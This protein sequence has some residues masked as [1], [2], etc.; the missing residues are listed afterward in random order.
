M[1][2]TTSKT[3]DRHAIL[4]AIKRRYGSMAALAERHGTDRR[5]LTVALGRPY[6]K[7]EAIIAKALGVSAS[8]LWP[9][10]YGATASARRKKATA[11]PSSQPEK[12]DIANER[13]A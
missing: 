2:R 11:A 12:F 9:D 3:W 5:H 1:A 4:A 13:A 6:L 10:R 7:A 8:E